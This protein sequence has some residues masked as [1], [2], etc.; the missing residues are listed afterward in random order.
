ML[1]AFEVGR[2]PRDADTVGKAIVFA[3]QDVTIGDLRAKLEDI[4]AAGDLRDIPHPG[5]AIRAAHPVC[6]VFAAGR[7]AA[8]CR[9]E[10]V[11]IAK[12]VYR[13]LTA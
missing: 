9:G 5:T 12:R 13:S 11:R 1:P 2:A 3:R 8:Q 4:V 10:L 6:T 7:D